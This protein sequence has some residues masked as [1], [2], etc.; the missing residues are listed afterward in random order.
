MIAVT[1][2]TT[3][4]NKVFVTFDEI[5]NLLRKEGIVIPDNANCHVH[6]RHAWY[7]N[8]AKLE[9][10]WYEDVEDEV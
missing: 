2:S 10:Y 6:E 8:G 4:T 5:R 9:F 3:R 7:R 1:K